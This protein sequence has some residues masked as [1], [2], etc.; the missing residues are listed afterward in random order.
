[1]KGVTSDQAYPFLA[2]ANNDGGFFLGIVFGTGTAVA[3][4]TTSWGIGV[5]NGTAQFPTTGGVMTTSARSYIFMG[6]EEADTN[7]FLMHKADGTTTITKTD[8]GLALAANQ[9][10]YLSLT[11]EPGA[12]GVVVVIKQITGFNAMTTLHSGTVT[13]NLPDPGAPLTTGLVS[14]NSAVADNGMFLSKALWARRICGTNI[15]EG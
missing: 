8:L 7:W 3:A 14:V 1:V 12:T 6:K 13:T 9:L 15:L 4:S 11:Q 5:H 10:F 2:N